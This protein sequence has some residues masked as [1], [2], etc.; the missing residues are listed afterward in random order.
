MPQ[1]IIWNRLSLA[2]FGLCVERPFGDVDVESMARILVSSGPA[3]VGNA[4]HDGVSIVAIGGRG[5]GGSIGGALYR[6]RKGGRARQRTAAS[7]VA[8]Q[9]WHWPRRCEK[10]HARPQKADSREQAKVLQMNAPRDSFADLATLPQGSCAKKAVTD[11]CAFPGLNDKTDAL[12]IMVAKR[13]IDL[14][15]S[16]D[17]SG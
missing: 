5:R 13:I 17:A 10:S 1:V 15:E 6:C 8:V 7:A 12:T 9:G 2:L 3:W 14:A 4:E 11:V 16:R